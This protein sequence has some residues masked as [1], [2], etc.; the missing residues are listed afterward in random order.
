L[1][2]RR[3]NT[4]KTQ[5]RLV[6]INQVAG[7]LIC[8]LLE[9]LSGRGVDCEVLTGWADLKDGER[10]PYRIRWGRRLVK[11]PAWKRLVTWSLFTLQAIWRLARIGRKTPVLIVTNP[12]WVML[13][14]PLL[15]RLFGVRYA[16]LV[17]DIYPDVAERMGMLRTGGLGSRIWR[18]LSRK[19]MCKAEAVITLGQTMAATLQGHL[20]QGDDV[21]I[22]V[23]PNWADTEFI[24]PMS[25][26]D[27]P[28]AQEHNLQEKIV[29]TYSG[30][31]GATHDTE[32]IITAA[33]MLQ[34]CPD[35]H[36]M[37]IGGGTR[38]AEVDQMVAEKDLPNLTLL[39]LQPLETLPLLLAASDCA[40]VCLDKGYEGVSVPSKTYS[41][42]ASGAALLAVST[43]GT[44]LDALIDQYECGLHIL[45][46]RP[47]L[48]AEA[49][50]RYL[51]APEML[52][53]HRAAARA[54]A[55]SEFS[56]ASATPRY[57]DL[58]KARFD[59]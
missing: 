10:P 1:F 55:E 30:A 40:I 23:I 25:K 45:P 42:L 51:S 50:R 22:E 39:P 58:L 38:R 14:A 5:P 6:V 28:F 20:R 46:G 32:S 49:I 9:S 48:L 2:S 12:P 31:F 33:E 36:F 53:S 37:L 52:A 3:K 15:K 44:E 27:N 26:K 57:Y 43:E 18:R 34:D 29:I 8:Q 11:A 17:Y 13:V 19:A 4:I 21:T 7:P 35:V 56:L 41:A 16:L 59:W 54:T 47:D 24:F